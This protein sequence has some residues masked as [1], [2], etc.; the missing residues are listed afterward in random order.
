MQCLGETNAQLSAPVVSV[1]HASTKS[2]HL[3][4]ERSEDGS[5]LVSGI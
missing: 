1:L 3:L 5:S 4:G 2:L